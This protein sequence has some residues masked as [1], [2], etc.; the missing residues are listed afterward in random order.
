MSQVVYACDR[1]MAHALSVLS[2]TNLPVSVWLL[3][4]IALQA[5][6]TEDTGCSAKLCGFVKSAITG[7]FHYTALTLPSGFAR[8]SQSKCQGPPLSVPAPDS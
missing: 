3:R 2:L 5:V 1:E 4:Y 8:W 6:W 7:C